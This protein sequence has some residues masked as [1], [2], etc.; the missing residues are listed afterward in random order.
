MLWSV[1]RIE[2]KRY[3]SGLQRQILSSVSISFHRLLLFSFEYKNKKRIHKETSVLYLSKHFFHNFEFFL[4]LHLVVS[5]KGYVE[6]GRGQTQTG[7]QNGREREL[8]VSKKR[9]IIKENISY[10]NSLFPRTYWLMC[11]FGT[12]TIHSPQRDGRIAD[13]HGVKESLGSKSTCNPP[14]FV[15][16]A[17][18]SKI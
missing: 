15:L 8:E 6:G 12:M 11:I 18:L 9:E 4:V 5:G 14:E 16:W 2:K 3:P 10:G 17:I 13:W 1:N 7:G